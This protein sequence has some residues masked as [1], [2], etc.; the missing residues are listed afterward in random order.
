[1][2]CDNSKLVVY[3]YPKNSEE[4]NSKIMSF[5]LD[6]VQWNARMTIHIAKPGVM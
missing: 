6:M 5:S 2:R 4:Q 3:I 1:M